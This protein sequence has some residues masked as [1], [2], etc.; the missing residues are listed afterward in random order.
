MKTSKDYIDQ[1]E[2]D[3]MDLRAEAVKAIQKHVAMKQPELDALFEVPPNPKMGDLAFPC[4]SLAKQFGTAPGVVSV[5]LREKLVIPNGFSKVIA[6]GP[7]INFFY[8]TTTFSRD[9]LKQAL[10]TNYGTSNIHKGKQVILDVIGLNP[11]KAGHIGHVRNG[12]IGDSVARLLTS[13]GFKTVKQSFVN[14][15]GV[16]TAQVFWAIKNLKS[17]LPKKQGLL[18]K[19]D[20]WQGHIYA[21]MQELVKKDPKI[22]KSVEELHLVL[23]SGKDLKLVKEQ[24]KFIEAC[25][26]AQSQTWARLDAHLDLDLYESDIVRSGVLDKVMSK[27]KESGAAYTVKSGKDAGAFVLKLSQFDYF[28]GM[29]NADKILIRPDGRVT[30]T[31]KDV[32]MQVWRFGLT[33]DFKYKLASKIGTHKEWA[34]DTFTGKKVD[35]GFN[36]NTHNVMV[37]AA[38]QI[39][40]IAVDFYALKALGYN[41]QF[42]NCYHLASGMVG[43]GGKAKISS[44]DGTVGLT[45]DELLDDAAKL[46]LKEVKKRNPKMSAT[47]QKKLAEDIGSSAMRYHLLKVDPVKFVQFKFEAALS[48]EGNTGPYLQY[49]LVRASKILKKSKQKVSTSVD[50]SLLA[51]DEEQALIKHIGNFPKIV[52]SAAESYSPHIV[53]NYAYELAQKFSTFYAKHRVI[54][55][56]LKQEKARLLLVSAFYETLK[57]SLDLLGITEV[58]VM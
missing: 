56:G 43:F 52:E 54:G 23:E 21:M 12:C 41:K 48:F 5:Q 18:K 10:K 49:A 14:D 46:A 8:D 20:Q 3:Y 16:P 17:K 15:L 29:K 28:K 50:F 25:M 19:E 13:V 35:L 27:L 4:F 40:V 36:K 1:E 39:Y 22:K 6:A 53:A 57:K 42:D 7:Y 55:A 32:S 11:N 2:E 30:Y 34:T 9:V 45:A 31:G 33:P 58:A 26:A 24:R 38:E 51:S 47:K 37:I 44:R